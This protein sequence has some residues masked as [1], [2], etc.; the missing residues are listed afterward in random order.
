MPTDQPTTAAPTALDFPDCR[1]C[2]MWE[3]AGASWPRP[4]KKHYQGELER[5]MIRASGGPRLRQQS[6][7]EPTPI[8]AVT[9]HGS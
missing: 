5:E 9:T 8:R 6:R 7:A 3:D 1:P 4:C 2:Q